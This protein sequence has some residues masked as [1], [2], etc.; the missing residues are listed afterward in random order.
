MD[1]VSE[2]V[3]QAFSLHQFL[4]F[5]SGRN[6]ISAAETPPIFKSIGEVGELNPED[7]SAFFESYAWLRTG[8]DIG[9]FPQSEPYSS[10]ERKT[11]ATMAREFRPVW[12][13][14]YYDL[15]A[16]LLEVEYFVIVP[17]EHDQTPAS[18]NFQAA[19][20]ANRSFSHPLIEPLLRQLRTPEPSVLDEVP[21][22]VN[23]P[24]LY[25]SFDTPPSTPSIA[26]LLAGFMRLI[27]TFQ[28]FTTLFPF[29]ARPSKFY[30]PEL[31]LNETVGTLVNARINLSDQTTGDRFARLSDLFFRT[32]ERLKRQALTVTWS[33]TATVE[34]FNSLLGRWLLFS[35]GKSARIYLTHS[36]PF[37]I[38]TMKG[39]LRF[40][41]YLNEWKISEERK[42]Y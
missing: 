38:R 18:E 9:Y 16:A 26:S 31:T 6:I 33:S 37:S 11:L 29:D 34:S 42:I 1:N 35:M 22:Y 30:G 39:V 20:L 23:L 27:D 4:N 14:E 41:Q 36:D 15:I 17:D 24:E 28:M 2:E 12:A 8:M 21:T 5:G 3:L 10:D 40:D 7:R 19:L 25:E 13:R 32:L